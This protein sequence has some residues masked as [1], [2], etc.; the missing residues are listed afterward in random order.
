MLA[1]LGPTCNQ[2]KP[3]SAICSPSSAG[4]NLGPGQTASRARTRNRAGAAPDQRATDQRRQAGSRDGRRHR[5]VRPLRIAPA[6][7]SRPCGDRRR[8]ARQ[9]PRKQPDRLAAH[10]LRWLWRIAYHHIAD[11]YIA[12]F[13][14]FI[15]RGLGG[16][17]CRRCHEEPIRD[18]TR[19]A[20][21]RHPGSSEPVFGLCRPAASS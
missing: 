3:S 10:S 9:A 4:C 19:H 7:G 6:L 12:L 15:L 13:T 14:S 2:R 20:A 16:H 21:C 17:P 11:S 5:P 8:H 18:P 1:P